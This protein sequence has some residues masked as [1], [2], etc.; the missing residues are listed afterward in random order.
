ME[1]RR[2]QVGEAACPGE[3]KK[4][5]T[6]LYKYAWIELPH[7]APPKRSP[8]ERVKDFREIYD[9]YDE[10]AAMEQARRC[11]SCPEAL[12]VEACPLHNRIPEWML[13]T[14][15][16]RFL[17]GAALACSTSNMPEICARICPQDRLCEGA[18]ILQGKGAEPVAIGGIE[19]FLLEYAFRHGAVDAAAVPPNGLCAAVVGAGPAG[20]ACADELAKRGYAV[21][22]FE[23][24][25]HPGGLLM[26][27]IPAFKLEKRIVD[28]R[29][30]VYRKRG[31]RFEF[32][33]RV[34]A[35]KPLADLVEQFDAVFLG[36][37]CWEPR[38][39][40]LKGADAEN[41]W[42]AL[43]FLIQHNG[44]E[45]L[46][47][48]PIDA[49]GK[50][51]L[52]LGGG[53]TAMDC[54]RTAL[55][56]GAREAVCVYRR[57]E[58][59]MPGSR[60]EYHNALEEGARFIF[61]T[62]PLEILTDEQNRVRAVRCI[63]MQLSDPDASGRRRPK[64]VPG[65]EHEIPADL[66]LIAFGFQPTKFPE[67]EV[68]D[69]LPKTRY[70]TL[71]TDAWGMTGMEGV[72]AGGDITRGPALVVQAA[73]DGRKAAAGIHRLL[74]RRRMEEATG[75]SDDNVSVELP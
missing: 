10:A 47:V 13:L 14:A 69:Q 16:G 65:A 60:R 24:H 29:V 48:P 72:F 68:F 12:C 38:G 50:R 33:V 51:V 30:E 40:D 20:L 11:L 32:G 49:K 67:D 19:R 61:L 44:R 9:T 75:A 66:V 74:M 34:G 35:D 37:G 63:R 23:A 31:V 15:E 55:R 21:T 17:D 57:D 46:G 26:N 52:V 3:I 73:A 7:S 22:V 70:G 54:L 53:D 41:V 5:K 4:S 43:P 56:N 59:N 18:C 27:G 36:I 28:R 71:E 2:N 8:E 45:P 64:P 25:Q 58:A 62:N 39:M 6:G 42:P 1:E